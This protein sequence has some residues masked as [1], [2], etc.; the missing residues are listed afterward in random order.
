MFLFVFSILVG[1]LLIYF[2]NHKVGRAG[3]KIA[4]EF[5]FK[6]ELLFLSVDRVWT[7]FGLSLF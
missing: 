2:L 1:P 3:A 6:R 4:P 5:S 7:D